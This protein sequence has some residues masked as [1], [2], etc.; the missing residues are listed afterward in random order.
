MAIVW[1]AD[2]AAYFAGRAFG[3]RKLAP[4]VS[5]GKTWEGVYGGLAAVAIYALALVPL[6]ADGGFAGAV[7]PLA[8][9]GLGRLRGRARRRCPSSAISASRC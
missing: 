9:I 2:T 8:V 7:S 4:Q 5:P 6:A 3:R 1:I